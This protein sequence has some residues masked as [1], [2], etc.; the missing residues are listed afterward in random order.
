MNI[1]D[2]VIARRLQ[3]LFI[4]YKHTILIKMHFSKIWLGPKNR[5]GNLDM[6]LLRANLDAHAM[7]DIFK[8]QNIYRF[9]YSYKD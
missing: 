7:R 5:E 8:K 6:P 4:Y 9:L 2:D 1:L 3:G